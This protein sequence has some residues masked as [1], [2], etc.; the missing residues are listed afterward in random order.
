MVR[1]ARGSI[2]RNGI[3]PAVAM[4]ARYPSFCVPA[5]PAGASRATWI[6]PNGDVDAGAVESCRA[7]DGGARGLVRGLKYRH[8][9]AR[10]SRAAGIYLI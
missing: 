1:T 4:C 3:I 6:H 9:E 7:A 5:V 10:V 2:L 8:H